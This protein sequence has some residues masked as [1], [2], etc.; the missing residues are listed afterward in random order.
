MSVATPVARAGLRST[1]TSSRHIPPRSINDSAVAAPTAPTPITP[2]F[3]VPL[4]RAIGT[5]TLAA[6]YQNLSRRPP[7][8]AS[9]LAA[10]FVPPADAA[11]P[12]GPDPGS[13]PD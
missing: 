5:V 9:L 12:A 2:T 7:T 10:P 3:T 11:H 1:R 13:H 4:L 8:E 6:P